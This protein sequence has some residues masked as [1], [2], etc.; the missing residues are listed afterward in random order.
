MSFVAEVL[1]LDDQTVEAMEQFSVSLSA[2]ADNSPVEL[3]DNATDIF[4]M[5]DDSK[6]CTE[7]ATSL[8]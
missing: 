7:R 5:D 4:I 8:W 1:V 6:C 3:P 2:P